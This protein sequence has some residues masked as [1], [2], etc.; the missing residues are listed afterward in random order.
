MLTLKSFHKKYDTT[1]SEL[2]IKGR[3]F[4]FFMARNLEDFVDPQDIFQ[5]FPLWIKIWEASFVLAEYLAGMEAEEG[6]RLLEIGCGI[7]VVGI[8][9][10]SFG[11]QVTMTEYNQDALNFARANALLNEASNLEIRALD[12]YNPE[13]EGA[14]DYIVGSEV[15]YRERDFQ[16]ILQLF[17]TYLKK[18][19]EIILAEGIRKTSMAFMHQMSDYFHITAQ[20]KVLRSKEKEIAIMLCR[21]KP[22]GSFG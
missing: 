4:P 9:A 8:V 12:W 16:P 21:M 18:R 10:S 22:K 3:T 15:L 7:G 17:K 19:G 11:H 1:T 14:F 5:D 6:K 20:K 2:V 13:I